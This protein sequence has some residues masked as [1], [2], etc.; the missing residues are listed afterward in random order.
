MTEFVTGILGTTCLC[1]IGFILVKLCDLK[2]ELKESEYV[3]LRK[4][5]YEELIKNNNSEIKYIYEQPQP[6]SYTAQPFIHGPASLGPA[7]SYLSLR[8]FSLVPAPLVPAPLVSAPLVSAPLVSAPLVPAPASL[9]PTA[10]LLA[11]ASHLN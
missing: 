10:P 1:S 9:S 2:R 5:Q 3:F 6:P 8:Q 7:S 11:P 4:D